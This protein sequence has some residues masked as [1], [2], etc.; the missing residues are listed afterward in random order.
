MMYT[1][2]LLPLEAS[3]SPSALAKWLNELSAKGLELVAVDSR[4][5]IFREVL[6]YTK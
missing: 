3:Y 4:M 2:K 5:Y 6:V 1:V